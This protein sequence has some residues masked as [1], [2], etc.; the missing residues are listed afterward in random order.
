M[1]AQKMADGLYMISHKRVNMFLIVQPDGCILIDTGFPDSAD[2]VVAA[3]AELG[4][5]PTDIRHILLTHNHP[6]HIGSAAVLQKLTGAEVYIHDL[7]APIAKAG[8][9]FRPVYPAP[10]LLNWLMK[11][12]VLGKV[13]QVDPVRID[14]R[15]TD[16]QI[17]PLAGGITVIHVPGHCLGQVAFFWPQ[18]GGV[19]FAADTC[20]NLGR[21]V[22]AFVYEDFAEG[23]R[24]LQKLTKLDC[25]MAGFG[26]G[27]AII[28]GAGAQ[29]RAWVTGQSSR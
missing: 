15:L 7:D 1:I 29:F 18:H 4:K 12:F 20:M 8:G 23:K 13:R 27:N 28:T 14:H 5:K 11:K 16:S 26:H 6:D 10:G 3:L 19:L 21:L 24:S 22:W 25:Q 9:G 2:T 17:L